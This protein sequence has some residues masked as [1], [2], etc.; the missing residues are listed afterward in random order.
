MNTINERI[1]FIRTEKQMS[2]DEFGK[3]IGLSRS[4]IGCYEKGIRDITERSINDI[5]REFNVNKDWLVN[6]IGEPYIIGSDDLKLNEIFAELTVNEN[7]KLQEAIIQLSELE[8]KYIDLI[9]PL[10]KEL[11][12]KSKC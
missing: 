6:G 11:N 9:L 1:K 8:E 3:V 10:I 12:N 4:Q 5:C 7:P 2:Q